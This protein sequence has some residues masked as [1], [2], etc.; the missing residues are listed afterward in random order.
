MGDDPTT[1]LAL[2]RLGGEI[3]IKAPATRRQFVNRLLRN[4]GDALLSEGAAP[5]IR[6]SSPP[7]PAS[8]PQNRRRASMRGITSSGAGS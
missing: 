1:Q 2:L 8:S 5:S 3:T 7:K 4:L 6:R